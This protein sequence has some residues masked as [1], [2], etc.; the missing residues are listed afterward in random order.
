[1]AKT[2]AEPELAAV[3]RPTDSVERRKARPI[4]FWAVLGAA[5]VLLE[6]WIY[7]SWIGTGEATRVGTGADPVP[8]ATKVWAVF[9][10]ASGCALTVAAI[11]IVVRQSRRERRLSWDAMMVIAWVS[12]YWQDP[13]INYTRHI[14]FYTSAMLNFGS[15]VE[16]VPGWRSPNGHLLPEPL[17]F[18]GNAYFW[19]GPMATVVACFAMRRARARW[20]RLGVPGTILAGLAAMAVLDLALEVIFIRTQLYSYPGAIREL[21]VWGGKRYQ[22]PI[23]EALLWGSVW[24]T[25]GALRFFRDDRGRSVVE[26]GVDRVRASTRARTALRVLALVG[27]ANVAMLIYSGAMNYTGLYAD[28]FPAGYPSYLKNGQCGVGTRYECAGPEVPVPMGNKARAVP[29]YSGDN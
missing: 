18:S 23:Y 1:M 19:M 7:G 28:K 5:F 24:T 16:R 3:S 27:V 9:F 29:P 13:L 8:T 6:L 4:V 21:S 26:R 11:V 14:Y 20:P 17:L 12:L 15:W 10:Q 2:V 22:F 25:M